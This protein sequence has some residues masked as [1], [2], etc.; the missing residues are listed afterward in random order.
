VNYQTGTMITAD[1]LRLHTAR[2]L[3]AGDPQA[4]V[5]IVHGVGEHS[6]RYTHL[7]RQLTARGYAVCALDHRGHGHSEGPRAYFDDFTQAVD[8]VAQFAGQL[9]AE[10]PGHRLFMFGHSMGALVSLLYTLR[11]QN[12]LA[13]WISSGTTL[14][15]D[16]SAHALLVRA[17]Q[18]LSRIMPRLPY[19]RIATG[20]L[21][22]DPRVAQ[23]YESDPLVYHRPLRMGMVNAMV[24]YGQ[25]ARQQLAKLRLP[26]LILHGGADAITPATGSQLLHERAAS[27]DKTLKIYDG[28][29]H[30]IL[31]EPEGEM[32]MEDIT[33]WLDS[34]ASTD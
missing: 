3:P 4:L 12:H 10:Y 13:G 17:G 1:G 6:G 15:L 26:L 18:L 8:E 29:Q 23:A 11:H 31:N 5:M 34:R 2:W 25:R 24:E 16:T 9:R 28:L 14:N 33:A 21:S 27:P 7:A 30:E 20:K 19:T 22:R 32:V